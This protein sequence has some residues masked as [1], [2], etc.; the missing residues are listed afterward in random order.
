MFG[1]KHERATYGGRDRA[2]W[3]LLLLLLAVVLLPTACLLWMMSRAMTTSASAVREVLADA[4]RGHLI[5]LQKSGTNTGWPR[6]HNSIGWPKEDR[7]SGVSCT[8]SSA[9]PPLTASLSVTNGISP[10]TQ[11]HP[12]HQSNS[13]PT[14]RHGLGRMNWSLRPRDKRRNSLVAAEAYAARRRMPDVNLAARAIVAQARCLAK[15]GRRDQAINLLVG[16]TYKRFGKAID[17]AGRLIIVDAELRAL[18]LI[19]DRSSLY[20][21]GI[22]ETRSPDASTITATRFWACL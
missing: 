7:H 18:E 16:M 6:W 14:R 4:C 22:A 15:A 1:M 11:P 12:R 2:W 10:F 17:V 20:F 3:P 5:H 21:E 19:G 9:R 8:P 13:R